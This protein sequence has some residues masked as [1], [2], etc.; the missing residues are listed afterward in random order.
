MFFGGYPEIPSYVDPLDWLPREV[1][2]QGLLVAS[3]VL[4]KKMMFVRYPPVP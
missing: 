2:W 4:F 1:Y 3:G